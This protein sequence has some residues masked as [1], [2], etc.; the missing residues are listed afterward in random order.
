M[1]RQSIAMK[2]A[3]ILVAVFMLAAPGPA[4]AGDGNEG[5]TF[6]GSCHFAGTVRFHPPLTNAARPAT[7]R[8]RAD[9]Q[10]SGTF[11]DRRGNSHALEGDFVTYVAANH[12]SMSCGGGVAEGG[13]YLSYRR[14]RLRFALTEVRATGGATLLIRGR[15]GG[16]A[17]GLASVSKEEDPLEIAQKCAGPGLDAARVVIDLATLGISG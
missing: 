12:G 13:G 8:A 4:A 14:H 16:F 5:S 7:G 17:E 9:G 3:P 2:R 6:A 10:C 11:T 1:R 15:R